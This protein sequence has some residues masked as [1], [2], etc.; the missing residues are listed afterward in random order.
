MVYFYIILNHI[1]FLL[2]ALPLSVKKTLLIAFAFNCKVCVKYDGFRGFFQN[3]MGSF[4][5]QKRDTQ[6][7]TMG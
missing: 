2:F 6:I 5:L 7:H 4:V 1:S 3:S